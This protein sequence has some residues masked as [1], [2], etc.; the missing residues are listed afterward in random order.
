MK[1][2]GPRERTADASSEAESATERRQVLFIVRIPL[3]FLAA[4][5]INVLVAAFVKQLVL[6]VDVHCHLEVG[7]C[8]KGMRASRPEPRSIAHQSAPRALWEQRGLSEDQ[9]RRGRI[10]LLTLRGRGGHWRN[11]M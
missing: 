1:W 10:M 11:M 3:S 5:R 9:T 6:R 7:L 8:R 4:V 2:R